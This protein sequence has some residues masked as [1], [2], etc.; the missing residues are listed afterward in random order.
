[1][2]PPKSKGKQES[3]LIFPRDT[4]PEPIGAR[5]STQAKKGIMFKNSKRLYWPSFLRDQQTSHS[6]VEANE[7]LGFN[8]DQ[9]NYNMAADM[10]YH[11]QVSS[12]RLLTNNPHK[13]DALRSYGI[14]VLQQLSLQ[15]GEN[16]H[17]H[18][19]LVTKASKMNHLLDI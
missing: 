13:V 15:V 6:L 12:V 14:P 19:Y 16:S 17:N 2:Q 4:I 8:A 9:R 1:M 7:K 18:D 11:L 10:L 5:F 3:A